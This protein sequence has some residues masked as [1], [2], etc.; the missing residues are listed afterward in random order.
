MLLP[1]FCLMKNEYQGIKFK[2]YCRKS[3]EQ[4]EKQALSI[5]S[6]IDWV[7]RTRK[8][9]GIALEKE[10]DILDESKSAK[11][12]YTRAVFNQ[13]LK[14][15]EQGKV[16][17][18][19]AWLPDRLS[20]NAGDAGRIIDLLDEGK[21]KVI[22]CNGQTFRNTP[23]DKFFFGMLCSQAKM[24]NDNKGESVKRGLEKKRQMGHPPYVPKIG[25]L[26]NPTGMKGF[27]EWQVDPIRFPLV[28]QLLKL[29]L[30][31]KYSV[32]KLWEIAKNDLKLTTKERRRE[33]GK[34]IARSQL[35]KTLADP[36]YA[37]FFFH[38]E[39]RYELDSA[40]PRAISEDEH[41]EI[42]R[43]MGKKGK[44][45]PKTHP[46]LYNYFMRD[47]Q[48]NAVG[49][50]HKEQLICTNCKKKFSLQNKTNC[51]SCDFPIEKMT[52][53]TRLSYTYYQSIRER[54]TPG[55]RAI[56]VE[57]KS[58]NTFLA[59]YFEENLAIS[60]ELSAWCIKH[61]DEIAS[62]DVKNDAERAKSHKERRK[63]LEEKLSRLLDV[64]L[65]RRD[66][67][68]S[69]IEMFDRKEA[70]IKAELASLKT[71][72][73]SSPSDWLPGVTE[74]FNLST[75]IVEIFKNGTR[76]EKKEALSILSSNL[77]LDA[78]KVSVYNVG[79]IRALTEGLHV[80]RSVNPKFEPRFCDAD[81]DKTDTFM[82]VRPTMLRR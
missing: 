44:P 59:G 77:T 19:I 25:F 14:E 18:I 31:G 70:E 48:G 33:G 22:I 76:E 4:E 39:E 49:A 58:I 71:E 38:G 79:V 16:Q 12:S 43:I 28:T 53:P 8:D 61:I 65:S 10:G 1:H 80:A 75:E 32:P 23:S 15:I 29:Y 42:L 13:L 37:G 6:Q 57:E 11:K 72:E 41:E 82:S 21:L 54:K 26:D 56:A 74:K 3:S 7:E 47:A 40:L 34:L 81:K 2:A 78:G 27:K 51:P 30:T 73:T 46:A 62:K 68:P 52:E 50:D 64:R 35:Y 55:V 45:K 36:L 67:S 24:E 63:A 17:G 66:I 69:D 20:R 60:P 9:L 5:D